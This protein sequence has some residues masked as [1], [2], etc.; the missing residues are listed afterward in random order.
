MVCWCCHYATG[1]VEGGGGGGG[2]G[3]NSWAAW[4]GCGVV[5]ITRMGGGAF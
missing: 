2:G 3:P 4:G 1:D 5:S